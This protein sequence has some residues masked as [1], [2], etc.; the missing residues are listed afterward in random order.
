[1]GILSWLLGSKRE[2]SLPRRTISD[3]IV[4]IAGDDGYPATDPQL[5][6]LR[7]L[8]SGDPPHDV[9]FRQA[10]LILSARDYSRV[11]LDAA[12]ARRIAHNAYYDLQSNVIA[13]IVSDNELS[14]AVWRWSRRNFEGDDE[15]KPPRKDKYWRQVLEF[16][17][18]LA[19][20]L[21]G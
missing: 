2:A 15:W 17:G 18:P 8:A 20:R 14:G 5:K 11:V 7:K 3:L 1:M 9:T 13:F 4:S 19:D 21:G 6:E 16:V 10:S 12:L